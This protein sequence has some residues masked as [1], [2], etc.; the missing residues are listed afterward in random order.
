MLFYT[1]LPPDPECLDCK[2]FKP[3]KTNKIFVTAYYELSSMLEESMET[4]LQWLSSFSLFY[5]EHVKKDT[6]SF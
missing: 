5:T 4:E 1:L 6:K 2:A 3:T